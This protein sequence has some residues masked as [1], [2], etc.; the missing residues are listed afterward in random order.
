[1]P[2][3]PPIS[4]LPSSCLL[5]AFFPLSFSKPPRYYSDTTLL[6]LYHHPIL[7][8]YHATYPPLDGFPSRE[9]RLP[10]PATCLV[11]GDNPPSKKSQENAIFLAHLQIFHYLCTA[12]QKFAD[13][14]KKRLLAL[15]LELLKSG[16][17]PSPK[18]RTAINAHWYVFYRADSARCTYQRGRYCLFLGNRF[19]RTSIVKNKQK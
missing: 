11:L 13:I 5:Y 8:P 4:L 2:Y 10:I 18:A 9:S 7:S 15:V 16:K 3:L 19:T 6:P 14:I 1:M 12:N 17:F